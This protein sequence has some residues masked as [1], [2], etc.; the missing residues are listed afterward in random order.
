MEASTAWKH[1]CSSAC[2]DRDAKFTTI[3]PHNRMSNRRFI[4]SSCTPTIQVVSLFST[5]V[6]FRTKIRNFPSAMQRGHVFAGHSGISHI[7]KFNLSCHHRVGKEEC[8]P[9][10]P[11]L[12][13]VHHLRV[14]LPLS[15]PSGRTHAFGSIAKEWSGHRQV[16]P[17]GTSRLV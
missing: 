11:L 5:H 1:C 13:P 10:S 6:H 2:T 9:P 3:A 14:T 7:P 12:F 4:P 16:V 15:F 17:F 8:S